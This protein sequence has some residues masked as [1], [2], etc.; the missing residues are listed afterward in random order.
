[1]YGVGGSSIIPVRV[2]V[3]TAISNALL[4]VFG[5]G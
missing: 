2:Q 4:S 3:L 5:R 1:M